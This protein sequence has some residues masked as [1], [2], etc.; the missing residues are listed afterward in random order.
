MSS[1]PELYAQAGRDP[2]VAQL[3]EA[4]LALVSEADRPTVE[5][6][7][8]MA[9]QAH[10][11]QTRDE[12]SPYI[13][14]PVR[15]ALTLAT[16]GHTDA[17]LLAA[18]LLHDTL[19]DTELPAATIAS[20]F[21]PRVAALVQTVSRPPRS[22]ADRDAIYH[23]QLI[24]GP[25]EARV[26]KVADRLDNLSFLHLSNRPGKAERYLHETEQEVLPIAHEIGGP[27][28]DAFAA[29]WHANR[30]PPVGEQR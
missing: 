7:F 15:V 6:A 1:I 19:E 11:G 12:G 9:E 18:A 16:H 27:L 26:L 24:E 20:E 25:P 3:V 4:L 21:S 30:T 8:L 14:H 28:G 22:V 13:I 2:I 17:E 29:W 23:R 10:A 5:R